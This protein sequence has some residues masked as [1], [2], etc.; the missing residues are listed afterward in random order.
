MATLPP[1]NALRAFEAAARLG[2][3]KAAADALHVTPAAVSQQVKSLEAHLDV[4]LFE[5]LPRGLRLTEAGRA[6]QPDLRRG[7]DHL[8]RAVGT[9]RPGALA[10][11]LNISAAPSF[12][13]LWLVPRLGGFLRAYPEIE[14]RVLALGTPPDLESGEVDVRIPYGLGIYPGLS[15]ALLMNETIFP[16]ASPALLNQT[17]LRRMSD[18]RDHVLL[19]DINIGDDEPTM[20]WRRWLRDARVGGVDPDR[21]VQFSD[22][23]LLTEAAIAGYGVALGRT[24]LVGAD[25]ASGRLVRPLPI[26]RPGDYAYYTVTTHAGRERPRVQ[27]LLRWLSEEVE[28]DAAGDG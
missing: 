13:T 4:R 23:V 17:P 20:T 7:L 26:H 2:G 5:R 16:V 21:G 3:F 6:L 10:G 11:R 27:A 1:L 28:R 22:S 25:L 12:A 8:S 18:L 14:L 9:L 19:H 24:S 15:A